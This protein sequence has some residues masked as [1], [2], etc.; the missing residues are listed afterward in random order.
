[1]TSDPAKYGKSQVKQSSNNFVDKVEFSHD[2]GIPFGAYP[3]WWILLK[4]EEEHS[5]SNKNVWLRCF[6]ATSFFFKKGLR[7]LT[8]CEDSDKLLKNI[9]FIVLKASSK[10]NAVYLDSNLPHT[11]SHCFKFCLLYQWNLMLSF[12]NEIQFSLNTVM[13]PQ[14]TKSHRWNKIH[15]RSCGKSPL[16]SGGLC[17]C[18]I[19][20]ITPSGTTLLFKSH[21][22][23]QH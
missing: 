22:W 7:I 15:E 3:F 10:E 8:W 2:V 1:M 4:N 5:I 16:N 9:T 18:R 21:F 13:R 6:L 17:P 12:W 20:Q 14:P 11:L 19:F 23:R